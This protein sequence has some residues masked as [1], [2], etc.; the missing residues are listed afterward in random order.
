MQDRPSGGDPPPLRSS[1]VVPHTL[2]EA[3]AT[4]EDAGPPQSG[5]RSARCCTCVYADQDS[6]SYAPLDVSAMR[7]RQR[8]RTVGLVT[9]AG[10]MTVGILGLVA[11]RAL[12]L[13][14]RPAASTEEAV[15]LLSNGKDE[16][17]RSQEPQPCH[18][19]QGQGS[20]GLSPAVAVVGRTL[21]DDNPCS[22]PTN[23]VSD[24]LKAAKTAAPALSKAAPAPALGSWQVRFDGVV[25]IRSARSLD[26]AVIGSKQKCEV[27]RGYEEKG[28]LKLAD[29]PGYLKISITGAEYILLEELPRYKKLSNGTC[30]DIGWH[31]INDRGLC[32]KAASALDLSDSSAIVS[33]STPMPEGCY[34]DEVAHKH[35]GQ[36][37]FVGASPKNRGRGADW[38]HQ[39]ICASSTVAQEECHP[40]ATSTSTST[41][42]MSKGFPSLFCMS[43]LRNVGYEPA[44][45]KAQL[46]QE[47]GIFQCDEWAL[48]SSSPLH[49]GKGPDGRSV[50][51]IQFASAEVGLSQDGFAAN[52]LLFMHMWEAVKADGRYL[53][54]D[55]IMKVDPDCVLIPSRLRAHLRPHMPRPGSGGDAGIYLK[56]CNAYP[57]SPN[58]PMMYG[59]LEVFSRDALEAY[60]AGRH[61]C[62]VSLQWKEWGEDFFMTKC[63]DK[64][65]VKSVDDFTSISDKRC[66]GAD[67]QDGKSAAYHDF[68]SIASWFDCWGQATEL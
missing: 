42:T 47:V 49:L 39:P 58:F 14:R 59:S 53:R 18:Q 3:L 16:T 52:T 17:L 46:K 9:A 22:P 31:S 66:G 65:G 45:M 67:C 54:N 20:K 28:W 5:G 12:G 38:A 2:A 48:F 60:F 24:L 1:V 44:L 15:V 51:A 40:I 26:S 57:D 36:A 32:E 34:W 43:V 61:Q 29:E 8:N 21:T 41:T 11:V 35:H 62:E 19:V 68:K 23:L 4:S 25:S 50:E 7:L 30:A 27:V 64:L 10:I 55:F 63:L 33:Q 6:G 37:L 56:N 13:G